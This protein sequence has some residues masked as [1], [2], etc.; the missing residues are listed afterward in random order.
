MEMDFLKGMWITMKKLN[1][2]LVM[3]CFTENASS[4]LVFPMGIAY[5]SSSMK[6][7]GRFNVF[8][9]NLNLHKENIR[10]ALESNIKQK[11]IDVVLLGGLSLH[12]NIINNI[13]T[14]VKSI[15]LNL[16]IIVG[17]G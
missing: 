4:E 16:K 2:L 11:N 6:A 14:F 12:Y 5:I 7:N 17:G 9:L 13:V 8:N 15:N 10:K 3:P 1:Y